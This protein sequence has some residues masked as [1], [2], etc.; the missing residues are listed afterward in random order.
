MERYWKHKIHE[1]TSYCEIAVLLKAADQGPDK[2]QSMQSPP[3]K[4]VKRLLDD[5]LP[6]LLV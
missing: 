5:V 3:S 1:G 6:K 2:H 4:A